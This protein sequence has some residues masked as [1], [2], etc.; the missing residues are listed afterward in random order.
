MPRD[1]LDAE[2][3]ELD[4]EHQRRAHECAASTGAAQDVARRAR[5]EQRSGERRR[6]QAAGPERLLERR[7]ERST[8]AVNGPPRC[9]CRRA[10]EERARPQPAG[11]R[12]GRRSGP[13]PRRE[14][15]RHGRE[16]VVRQ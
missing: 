2:D 7:A 10:D 14:R 3:A 15:D 1:R 9:G 12:V 6:H 5:D 16:Q 13:E 11:D 4:G 8:Q